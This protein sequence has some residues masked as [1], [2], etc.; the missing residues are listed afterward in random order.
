VKLF[1]DLL[2][3]FIALLLAQELLRRAPRRTVAP[4]LLAIPFLLTPIWAQGAA[5]NV[6]LEFDCPVEFSWIKLYSMCFCACWIGAL[7]FTTLG[8]RPEALFGTALILAASIAEAVAQD[9]YDGSLV[10][11]LNAAAGT[12]LIVTLPYRWGAVKVRAD[13]RCRD[14]HFEGMTRVWI[15][16]YSLWNLTFLYLNFPVV[17]GQQIATLGV[18]LI[19]GLWDPKRWL[20]VRTYTLAVWLQ[21][22]FT[23]PSFLVHRMDTSSWSNAHVELV[24]AGLSTAYMLCLAF[25]V[26]RDRIRARPTSAQG[27]RILRQTQRPRLND[28]WQFGEI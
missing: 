15:V 10:H 26:V 21:T 20:Q 14:L 18:A 24:A 16:G 27:G 7:C 25:G 8:T 17:V 3:V 4:L 11:C 22:I 28:R 23:F 6:L 9:L 19:V 5:T 1:V 13:G 2:L 12:L